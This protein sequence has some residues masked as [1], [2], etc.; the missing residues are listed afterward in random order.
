MEFRL[1][2]IIQGTEAMDK[3]N[4]QGEQQDGVCL[5]DEGDHDV[6]KRKHCEYAKQDL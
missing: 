5:M 3:V 6:Y 2:T 1:T 4:C